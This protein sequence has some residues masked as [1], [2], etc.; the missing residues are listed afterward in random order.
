M[1]ETFAVDQAKEAASFVSQ[2][3]PCAN[4]HLTC[5]IGYCSNPERVLTRRGENI[6]LSSLLQKLLASHCGEGGTCHTPL[7]PFQS[8]YSRRFT[9]A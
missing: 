7:Q 1:D 6:A 9:Y 4:F 3:S 2:V 8:S 5:S